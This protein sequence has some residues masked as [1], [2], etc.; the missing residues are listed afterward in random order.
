MQIAQRHK[1]L[2]HIE[3]FSFHR[4]N[5]DERDW[6]YKEGKLWDWQNNYAVHLWYREY[7]IE[8]DPNSIR[9]WNTTAGEVFRYIYYGTSAVML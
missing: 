7:G 5:W 6:L 9:M 2:V 3:W 4:P 8:H 1:H